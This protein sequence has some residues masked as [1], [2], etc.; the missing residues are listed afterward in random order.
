MSDDQYAPAGA[1]AVTVGSARRPRLRGR[2]IVAL[3]VAALLV[4]AL[5]VVNLVHVPYVIMRPGPAT[6]TLG[7]NGDKDVIA[8]SG[9]P[10]YPTSGALD[11]TTVSMS[12]GPV[13]PVS[14]LSY[15]WAKYVEDHAEI[16]P[17][18]EWFPKGTTKAQV[19]QQS[20]AQ[21]TGS[22]EIATAVGLRKAG[23]Q[24]PEDVTVGVIDEHGTGAK[25]FRVD[26]QLVRV[27]GTQVT[28]LASV[29][30]A[31]SRAKPGSTV[32][33]DVRRRGRPVTLKVPTGND[34]GRAVFG[35]VLNPVY[36]PK[37]KV[38]VNAGDVGG[39][40]A[41]LMFS[42]AIYDKVTKGALTGGKRVAGTGE[43]AEDGTVGPIGGI[44]Q[45]MVGA[46][47]AK[48]DFFLAPGGDCKEVVG[49]VPD[50]LTVVKVDTFDQARTQLGKI[51][52]G[53]TTGLPACS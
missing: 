14:V 4:I 32:T 15:L 38:T 37:Q 6:N 21:M 41:G 27:G 31:M 8:I 36:H 16:Y 29:H 13:Y 25:S 22:Q 47:D 19:Q 49:H 28:D 39:P 2:H 5:V 44:R 35:I 40:S 42:L 23:I 24:V 43:I 7:R 52:A 12:G 45:K 53:Q 3:V 9:T 51:A 17:E 30:T 11:F 18:R 50:G 26:D 34:G 33:V 48:A 10:T 1:S 46:R 20:T